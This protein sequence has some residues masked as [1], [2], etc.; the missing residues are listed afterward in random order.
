MMNKKHMTS[1]YLVDEEKIIFEE[2]TGALDAA[3]HRLKF[4]RI[5]NE[6]LDQA[7]RE[8]L[9]AASMNI[10]GIMYAFGSMDLFKPGI[11]K[12]VE[13]F[14]EIESSPSNAPVVPRDHVLRILE[15]AHNLA[16]HLASNHKMFHEK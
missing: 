15:V 4:R 10:W 16:A 5:C 8:A 14:V 2:V 1:S 13:S 12:L 6:N 11:G 9:E 3:A 7:E